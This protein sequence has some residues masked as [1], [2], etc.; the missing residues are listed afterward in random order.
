MRTLLIVEDDPPTAR[1]MARHFTQIGYEVSVAPTCATALATAGTYDVGVFD[2][3]LP[4]G[5]GVDVADALLKRGV[6]STAVFYSGT[7]DERLFV[8]R[9]THFVSKT[10]GL[11]ALAEVVEREAGRL[12]RVVAQQRVR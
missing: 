7:T 2:L 9:G 12:D 3:L 5:D 4:D 8:G 6:V 10:D 1:G 11:S